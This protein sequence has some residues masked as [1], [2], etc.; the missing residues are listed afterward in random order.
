MVSS[1]N[2]K[3]IKILEDHFQVLLNIYILG[4]S[5]KSALNNKYDG[6]FV[7]KVNTDGPAQKADIKLGDTIVEVDG[8]AVT[9][10]SDLLK[11]LGYQLEKK[12]KLKLF[13][14]GKFRTVELETV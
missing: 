11:I 3:K 6:A 7:I 4:M 9:D 8:I 10:G 12:F 2:I 1:I 5:I 14:D 13:K